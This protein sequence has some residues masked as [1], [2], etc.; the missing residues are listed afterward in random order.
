[1][2][3]PCLA[4]ANPISTEAAACPKCGHPNTPPAPTGGPA[5]RPPAEGVPS[6][7]RCSNPAT[8]RC[9]SCNALSCALHLSSIYVAHGRGGAYEL[10]CESCYQSAEAWK[11]FGYVV[12]AVVVVGLIL[13]L[14]VGR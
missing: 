13:F 9:Q 14:S 6:C 8:T 3:V 1:P 5:A 11:V 4:C 2:L 12:F 10:R 7:Y